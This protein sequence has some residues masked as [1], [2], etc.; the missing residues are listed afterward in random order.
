MFGVSSLDMEGCDL[1]LCL[2]FSAMLA[3]LS[4]K[5]NGVSMYGCGQGSVEPMMHCESVNGT[6]CT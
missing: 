1:V 5:I 3:V 4:G 2:L 6:S